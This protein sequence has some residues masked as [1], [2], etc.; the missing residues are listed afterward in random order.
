MQHQYHHHRRSFVDE[1]FIQCVA[2]NE[3]EISFQFSAGSGIEPMLRVTGGGEDE[4]ELRV[5]LTSFSI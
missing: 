1:V 3:I 5:I 2:V 4:R